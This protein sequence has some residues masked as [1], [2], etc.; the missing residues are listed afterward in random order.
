MTSNQNLHDFAIYFKPAPLND[1][2]E[3]SLGASSGPTLKPKPSFPG[4]CLQNRR[5]E[6]SGPL[7]TVADQQVPTREETSILNRF[8]AANGRPF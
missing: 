2:K 4:Y 8:P 7:Q 6:D 5:N 3:Q 1:R